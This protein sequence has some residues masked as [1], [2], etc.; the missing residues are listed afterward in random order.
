MGVF[1][2][3]I[4]NMGRGCGP[5]A[6]RLVRGQKDPVR[7]LECFPWTQ[8]TGLI[9]QRVSTTSEACLLTNEN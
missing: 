1:P 4:P 7:E 2:P 6:L 5:L 3:A 8:G 9:F